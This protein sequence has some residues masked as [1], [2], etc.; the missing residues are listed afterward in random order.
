MSIVAVYLGKEI[1]RKY[2][3]LKKKGLVVPKY[4]RKQWNVLEDK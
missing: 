1:K 3:V 4:E 2:F